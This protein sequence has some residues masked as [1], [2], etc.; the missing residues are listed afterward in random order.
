M[1]ITNPEDFALVTA[2]YRSSVDGRRYMYEAILMN[3][4]LYNLPD[5]FT[6]RT[7]EVLEVYLK[8]LGVKMETVDDDEEFIGE[9]EHNTE[10]REYEVGSKTIFCTANEMY[11]LKKLVKAYKRFK[12][13]NPS[14]ITEWEDAWDYIM[15]HLPF[16]KQFLTDELIKLFKTTLEDFLKEEYL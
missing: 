12:K 16:D 9:P 10:L 1:I 3:D 2:L 6:S 4:A 11:Y 7:S 8:S 15:D 13:D 5:N 14:E